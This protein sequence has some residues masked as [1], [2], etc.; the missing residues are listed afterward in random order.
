MVAPVDTIPGMLVLVKQSPES[1]ENKPFRAR[2][3]P[4]R[5]T[6]RLVASEK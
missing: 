1:M 4:A 2:S 6:K 5:V 3:S